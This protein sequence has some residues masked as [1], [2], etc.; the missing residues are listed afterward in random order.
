MRA[1]PTSSASPRGWNADKLRSL[2]YQSRDVLPESLS[3]AHM[4]FV[5]LAEGLAGFVVPSRLYGSWPPAGRWSSRPIRS[6][7]AQVVERVG[8]GIVIPP[9][10]PELL[11]EVI[12]DAHEGRYDST[13]WACAGGVRDGRRGTPGW[14]RRYR[15][16]LREMVA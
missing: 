5:G 11:A 2:P 13:R 10:R 9:S 6:E 15:E 12:R 16:L 1:T 14:F 4:H 7:T 8:C 3:S